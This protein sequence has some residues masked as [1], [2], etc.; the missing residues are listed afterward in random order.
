M[1]FHDALLQQAFLLVQKER[2]NPKQASLRRAVSTT[3]YALFHLLISEATANR[4]SPQLRTA[5][6]RAFDHST[7]KSASNRILDSRHCPFPGEDPTVVNKLKAVA[8]RFAR[9]Q[10]QR[11]VADYDNTTPWTRTDALKEVE[12]AELAFK[13]W[14]AIRHE[15][16]AQAF[17]ISL[18]VKHRS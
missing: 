18:L 10:E 17:L 2:K 14:K 7:M 4:S 13:D 15:R 9:L 11:H 12:D 1:A 8:R 5:L 3:S 16:I 6:G